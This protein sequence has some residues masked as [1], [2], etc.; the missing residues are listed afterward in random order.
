MENKCQCSLITLIWSLRIIT[1]RAQ[2]SQS[3]SQ[4]RDVLRSVF[5]TK[6]TSYTSLFHHSSCELY[7]LL[8]QLEPRTDQTY[9][10]VSNTDS[11][12]VWQAPLWTQ[13]GFPCKEKN[14]VK[15]WMWNNLVVLWALSLIMTNKPANP[16]F[17]WTLNLLPCG[18]I[19][20]CHTYFSFR[21][22]CPTNTA[23]AATTAASSDFFMAAMFTGQR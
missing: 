20:F 11:S 18:Q 1:Y 21:N 9:Q 22:L 2:K 12:S 6:Q 13:A 14:T 3:I 16:T 10:Y 7:T 23:K 15:S 8:T 19:P 5:C 17:S 4:Y